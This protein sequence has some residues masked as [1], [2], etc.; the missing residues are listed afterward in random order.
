MS[1]RLM[2]ARL[3]IARLL[4]ARLLSAL[5]WQVIS[6][7]LIFSKLGKLVSR[8]KESLAWHTFSLKFSFWPLFKKWKA[9]M[10]SK[11]SRVIRCNCGGRF[12]WTLLKKAELKK[13]SLLVSHLIYFEVTIFCP[14]NNKSTERKAIF[15]DP[16]KIIY[17]NIYSWKSRN[18]WVS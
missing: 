17:R 9:T 2:I 7:H 18:L 4:S 15:Q 13:R 12:E 10:C 16:T 11:V 3:L 8:Q 6:H 14:S 5:L 1:A